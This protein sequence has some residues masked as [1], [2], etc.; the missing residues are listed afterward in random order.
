MCINRHVTNLFVYFCFVLFASLQT[1]DRPPSKSDHTVKYSTDQDKEQQEASLP[2]SPSLGQ[3]PSQS[4][5]GMRLFIWCKTQIFFCIL[6]CGKSYRYM[7][8]TFQKVFINRLVTHQFIYFCF[9]FQ[10]LHKQ[11]I[12]HRA[13]LITSWFEEEILGIEMP[14][15]HS[16]SASAS[17]SSKCI[18]YIYCWLFRGFSSQYW[19]CYIVHCCIYA[20]SCDYFHFL[21]GRKWKQSSSK[22]KCRLYEW[23]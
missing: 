7:I 17:D 22:S 23:I 3:S 8:T 13:N 12:V 14:P 10:H 21:N 16:T 1:V 11:S 9:F 18:G 20:R 19:N 4:L 5:A 2:I 15:Y 6:W